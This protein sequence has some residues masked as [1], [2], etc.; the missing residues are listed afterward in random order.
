MFVSDAENLAIGCA[1]A[2]LNRAIPDFPGS[3]RANPSYRVWLDLSADPPIRGG[4]AIHFPMTVAWDLW[5]QVV[6]PVLRAYEVPTQKRTIDFDA[7]IAGL[8]VA[9][10]QKMKEEGFLPPDPVEP[11][12][13]SPPSNGDPIIRSAPR[14]DPRYPVL[15]VTS[16]DYPEGNPKLVY[17]EVDGGPKE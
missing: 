11:V 1:Y 2:L 16:I 17:P 7:L 12:P 4:D 10:T 8:D 3:T 15:D 6:V 14:G 9:L 13:A 5:Q